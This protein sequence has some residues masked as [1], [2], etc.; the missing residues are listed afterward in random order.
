[1][2]NAK[3]V[4]GRKI[5]VPPSWFY[6]PLT[7]LMRPILNRQQNFKCNIIDDPRKLK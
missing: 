2:D 7:Y 6:Y 1:M 4:R 3:K 5:K